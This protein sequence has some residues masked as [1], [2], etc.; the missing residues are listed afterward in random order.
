MCGPSR[1]TASSPPVGNT[2]NAAGSFTGSAG[3]RNPALAASATTV[4]L[5]IMEAHAAEE[6]P[7]TTAVPATAIAAVKAT[8]ATRGTEAAL[9]IE[10][11]LAGSA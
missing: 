10:L 9:A 7:A 6:T 11:V 4:V 1:T 3:R 2:R 5:A 8:K